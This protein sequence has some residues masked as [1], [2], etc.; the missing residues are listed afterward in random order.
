[1]FD[2]SRGDRHFLHGV[3]RKIDNALLHTMQNTSG[4][5]FPTL[6]GLILPYLLIF[7]LLVRVH[8]YEQQK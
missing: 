7:A 8:Y 3:K 6:S 5:V 1:M 2:F 4:K